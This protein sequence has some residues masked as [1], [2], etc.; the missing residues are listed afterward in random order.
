MF[1][2]HHHRRH[3]YRQREPLGEQDPRRSYPSSEPSIFSMGLSLL[4]LAFTLGFIVTALY[5]GAVSS[6]WERLQRAAERYSPESE[7]RDIDETIMNASVLAGVLLF[8][9]ST[10]FTAVK[11]HL[12]FMPRESATEVTH[13]RGRRRHRPRNAPA[14]HPEHGVIPE[15]C[16]RCQAARVSNWTFIGDDRNGRLVYLCSRCSME[17]LGDNDSANI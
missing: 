3:H 8:V 5:A 11:L 6:N 10:L 14:D 2:S 1:S 12:K 7:R 16:Q 9:A 13:D 15:S 17:V 4:L